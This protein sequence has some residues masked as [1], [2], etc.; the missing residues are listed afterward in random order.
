MISYCGGLELVNNC[1]RVKK[2]HFNL[3]VE[4]LQENWFLSMNTF[5]LIFN[6]NNLCEIK[7]FAAIITMC[8]SLSLNI[9]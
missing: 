7:F 5:M 1:Q 3:Q 8:I 4:I 9:Q 6:T 2:I